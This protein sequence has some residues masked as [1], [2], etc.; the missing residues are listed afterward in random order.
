MLA[1]ILGWVHIPN[2]PRESTIDWKKKICALL[3]I[4][5]HPFGFQQPD[6]MHNFACVLSKKGDRLPKTFQQE[7]P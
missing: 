5:I 3:Q 1:S 6:W 4:Q 2:E 7:L